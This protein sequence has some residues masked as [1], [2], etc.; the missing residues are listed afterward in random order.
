[1]KEFEE[2]FSKYNGEGTTLRAAQLRLL[3]I[4]KEFDKICKKYN[5]PYILDSGTCLGAVRHG[6]FIPWDDDVDIGMWHKD[7]KKLLKILSK[8]LSNNYFLQTIKTDKNY[9]R[10]FAKIT[11][12]NS[13]TIYKNNYIRKN[14]IFNGI[15]IDII[16]IE[17]CCS[18]KIQKVINYFYTASLIHIR[19]NTEKPIKKL[20]SFII[21][22]LFKLF[23]Q[24]FRFFS[25]FSSKEKICYSLGTGFNHKLQ[26]S[27]CFPPK[28][29]VFEGYTFCGP[30]KPHEYL[31]DL[32]GE[33]YM[34]LP[35]KEDRFTHSISIELY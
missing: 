27:N 30:A 12:K 5:L 15:S 10:M 22:P 32:Y 14:L 35:P 31:A 9:H 3:E 7:Y 25:L 28:P 19:A 6:G 16:P 26:Y 2:D 29:M 11:D 8:E 4:M 21:Y 24:I 17:K 13:K 18:K 1:M 33:D 34:N 23:T 20:I